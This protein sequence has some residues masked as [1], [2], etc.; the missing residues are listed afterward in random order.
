MGTPSEF[1]YRDH[2]ARDDAIWLLFVAAVI[3]VSSLVSGAWGIAAL[4]HANWLDTNDLPGDNATVWGIGLLCAATLQ[5]ITALLIFFGT[6]L[7]VWLGIAI[8]LVGAV[9]HLSVISAYPVWSLVG[10]AFNAL[11]IGLLVKHGRRRLARRG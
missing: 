6:R 7:G 11:I 10:I 3:F 8:A 9:L 4:A 2:S 5:G 1:R